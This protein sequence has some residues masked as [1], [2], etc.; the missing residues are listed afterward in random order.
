MIEKIR[1][2][3]L[4][5]DNTLWDVFPTIRYA[6][7]NSYRFLSQQYPKVTERYSIDDIR[8]LR[9]KIYNERPDLQHDLTAIRQQLYVEML[10]ECGYDPVDAKLLLNR[11]LVD[12]NKV[13]MYPDTLPALRALSNRYVLISLSDGNSDLSVIGID[14]Y[15]SATVYAAEVG[16]VKPHPAGFHLACELSGYG[17]EEIIHVGDHPIA[18]VD[19]ARRAGFHTMWIQ[20]HAEVWHEEFQPDFSIASMNEAVSILC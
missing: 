19:G 16:Y 12:R 5:L 14:Q 9:E 18:D 11:F 15:F 7:D 13:Q 3:T 6:E 17:P 20:R 10:N 4:D 2:I 1:A 8:I